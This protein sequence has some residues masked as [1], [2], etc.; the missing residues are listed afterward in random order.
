MSEKQTVYRVGHRT[1]PFTP[2]ANAMIRDK[3]T[4]TDARFLLV[5]VM[6]YPPDWEFN[7]GWLQRELGWGRD[8]TRNAIKSLVDNGYCKRDRNRNGNGTLSAFEYFFTDIPEPGPENPSVVKSTSD[9]LPVTGFQALVTNKE[10]TKHKDKPKA[11]SPSKGRRKKELGIKSGLKLKG[12]FVERAK[13]L[14]LPVDDL[15]TTIYAAENCKYPKGL[16]T[17]LCVKSLLP[18]FPEFSLE[19]LEGLDALVRPALWDADSVYRAFCAD[20][21]ARRQRQREMRSQC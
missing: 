15:L 11:L 16:F 17:T 1:L 14:G 20:V 5:F 2:L 18:D 6:S 21:E 8:K 7:I 12:R 10:S 13:G 3:R 9:A 19:N 4:S